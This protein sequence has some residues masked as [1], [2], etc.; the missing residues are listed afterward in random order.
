MK[1]KN[2]T[3]IES[4]KI[5]D[6]DNTPILAID[7]SDAPK[8]RVR[9][10]YEPIGSIDCNGVQI[11]I[12]DDAN[13]V[14]CLPEPAED[15]MIIVGPHEIRYIKDRDDVVSVGDLVTGENRSIIGYRT[16]TVL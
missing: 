1:L 15:T 12:F 16:L 10:H 2:L 4:L 6:Q 14:L 13:T 9:H 11:P 3:H 7:R 5:L 8:V